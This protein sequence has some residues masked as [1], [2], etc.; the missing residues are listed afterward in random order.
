MKKKT[1]NRLGFIYEKHRS[2]TF[3]CDLVGPLS[4]FSFEKSPKI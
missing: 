4:Q 2:T 3:G 1:L